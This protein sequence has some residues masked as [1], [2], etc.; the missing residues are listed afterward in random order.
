MIISATGPQI[1]GVQFDVL[2]QSPCCQ[3]VGKT[4]RSSNIHRR[5]PIVRKLAQICSIELERADIVRTVGIAHPLPCFPA[6]LFSNGQHDVRRDA[7]LNGS[8]N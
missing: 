4:A 1:T 6:L 7:V 3:L 8:G 2:A 5:N